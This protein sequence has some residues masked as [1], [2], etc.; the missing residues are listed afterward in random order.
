[1]L[2]ILSTIQLHNQLDLQAQ[3]IG[4]V[5]SDRNLPPELAATQLL[6]PQVLP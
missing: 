1:L 3:E 2:D 6:Q 4:N 5:A